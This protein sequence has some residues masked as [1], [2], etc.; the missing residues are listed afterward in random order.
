LFVIGKSQSARCVPLG[1]L[2]QLGIP[3]WM[4]RIPPFGTRTVA[5]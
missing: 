2:D 5:T 3:I 4:P 1:P